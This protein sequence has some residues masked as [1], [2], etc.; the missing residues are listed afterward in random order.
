MKSKDRAANNAIKAVI[1]TRIHQTLQGFK[2]RIAF[3]S[4]LLEN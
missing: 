4:D 3:K 2:R 1:P